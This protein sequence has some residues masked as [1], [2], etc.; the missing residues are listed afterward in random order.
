MLVRN[1]Y[2]EDIEKR[3]LK[4][5]VATRHEILYWTWS[6]VRRRYDLVI[7]IAWHNHDPTFESK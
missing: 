7:V 3:L 2:Y 1:G 6:H 4:L 5:S